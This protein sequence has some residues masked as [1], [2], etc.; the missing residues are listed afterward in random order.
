MI[1]NY[2]KIL[3]LEEGATEEVVEKRY[4]K[5]LIEF[6]PRKQ[7]DDLKEFFKQEQEKVK[8]AHEKISLSFI[9]IEEKEAKKEKKPQLIPI[10]SVVL[11]FLILGF[12]GFYNNY[13]TKLEAQLEE[14]QDL[15][16]EKEKIEEERLLEEQEKQRL[17]EVKSEKEKLAK[18]RDE[19]ERLAKEKAKKERLNQVSSKGNWSSIDKARFRSELEK[20][21]ELDVFGEYK[22]EFIECSLNKCEK[23]YTSYYNCMLAEEAAGEEIGEECAQEFLLRGSRESV[24]GNWS[25]LDKTI[26]RSALE[27]EDLD[28]FG[29][30]K[31][32]FIEC[33]LNK[34]EDNYS[35]YMDA[36][37]DL[38]GLGNIGVECGELIYQIYLE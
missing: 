24:K 34:C 25:D 5:L 36:E 3:G 35:S 20:V 7:S 26:F 22:S 14:I 9:N 2:Y 33:T 23:K 11:L 4:N 10:I 38:D 30:Y 27:A 13:E 21:V 29:E 32:E 37:I 17:I 31:S 16:L 1:K 19:K 28:A 15:R 6:D 18:E 8:E 12:I